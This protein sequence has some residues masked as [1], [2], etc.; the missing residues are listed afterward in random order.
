MYHTAFC[1]IISSSFV[2][3]NFMVVVFQDD[4]QL[5]KNMGMD[6]YRFSISWSRI[7]PGKF[8]WCWFMQFIFLPA[9][10]VKEEVYRTRYIG[11]VE[12]N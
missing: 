1:S 5:M 12:H 8:L 7:F 10:L 6:A 2:Y 9:G 11:P 4:I 3:L